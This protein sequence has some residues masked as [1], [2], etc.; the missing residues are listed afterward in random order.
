M[1]QAFNQTCRTKRVGYNRYN[2]WVVPQLR[3]PVG[4]IYFAQ[5]VIPLSPV[6]ERLSLRKIR[7]Y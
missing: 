7:C 4:Q 3:G 5:E 2:C 1:A 6:I